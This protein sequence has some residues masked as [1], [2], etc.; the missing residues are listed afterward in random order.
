V[1]WQNPSTQ[2]SVPAL[3]VALAAHGQPVT[4]RTQVG[5]RQT[6]AWQVNSSPRLLMPQRPEAVQGQPSVPAGQVRW[7]Q[8][9]LLSQ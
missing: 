7:R 5:T 9:L 8:V 4:P 2:V 1:A 3:Q 6:P